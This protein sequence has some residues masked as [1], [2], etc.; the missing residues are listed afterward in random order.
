MMRKRPR[1]TR[2]QPRR[3][4]LT[5]AAIE[6]LTIDDWTLMFPL[7]TVW[8]AG[9]LLSARGGELR[10]CGWRVCGWRVRESRMRESRVQELNPPEANYE[11]AA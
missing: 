11:F 8:S 7:L 10:V 1:A 9:V 2:V 5:R 3:V 6:H 4:P